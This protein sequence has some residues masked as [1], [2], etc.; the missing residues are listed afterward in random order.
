MQ[1]NKHTVDTG[2]HDNIRSEHSGAESSTFEQC[3]VHCTRLQR[4]V[5]ACCPI[6]APLGAVLPARLVGGVQVMVVL[7]PHR[8]DEETCVANNPAAP[9]NALLWKKVVCRRVGG[10]PTNVRPVDVNFCT[11][12]SSLDVGRLVHL[13]HEDFFVTAEQRGGFQK[14]RATMRSI[15]FYTRQIKTERVHMTSH[16]A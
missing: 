13:T 16:N 15:E 8:L 11:G 12:G 10:K 1:C 6:R 14:T 4:L 9:S 5:V 3:D 7:V 2:Q